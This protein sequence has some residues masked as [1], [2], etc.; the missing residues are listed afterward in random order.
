MLQEGKVSGV[1][2]SYP[3]QKS[4]VITTRALAV[5]NTSRPPRGNLRQHCRR[6]QSMDFSKI[7]SML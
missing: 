4:Q 6:N 1:R 2:L 3:S 5:F 7:L